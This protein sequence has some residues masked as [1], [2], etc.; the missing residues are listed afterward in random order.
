M[1]F[2]SF[3]YL[4]CFYQVNTLLHPTKSEGMNHIMGGWPGD[5]DP[6]DEDQVARFKK[7]IQKDESFINSIKKLG[8][9]RNNI[10]FIYFINK[11]S[12]IIRSL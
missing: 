4:Y 5:V 3:K 1:L 11:K 6:R 2:H 12:Y 9:V 8:S 10:S 7:K